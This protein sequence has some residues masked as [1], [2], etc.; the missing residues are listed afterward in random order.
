M[1]KYDG[2]IDCL[3]IQNNIVINIPWLVK[4]LKHTDNVVLAD[5]GA[6][7]FFESGLGNHEKVRGIIGDLDSLRP[8]VRE[9]YESYGVAV[10]KI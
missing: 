2:K 6:N 5:G 7:I 3:I 8:S 1:D 4:S 10:R 9:F